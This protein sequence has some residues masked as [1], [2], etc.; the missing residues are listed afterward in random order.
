MTQPLIQRKQLP[1]YISGATYNA[2]C[3]YHDQRYNQSL[4][5]LYTDLPR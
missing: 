1:K 3:Y 5:L 4:P 2:G